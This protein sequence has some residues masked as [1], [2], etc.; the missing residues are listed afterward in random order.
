[1][2]SYSL[3]SQPKFVSTYPP[4]SLEPGY[5]KRNGNPNNHSGIHIIDN[6][7]SFFSMLGEA[8]ENRLKQIIMKEILKGSV[9]EYRDASYPLIPKH[10]AHFKIILEKIHDQI[11]AML[12]HHS[13]V[14][15]IFF[16]LR[17]HEYTADS[18]WVS[19]LFEKL[20]KQLSLK[21][22]M[23]RIGH[24]WTREQ[25][26]ADKQHYHCALIL[27][28]NK[29]RRAKEVIERIERICENWDLP[30]PYIPKNCYYQIKRG[31][32]DGFVECFRR[33]SYNAKVN[34]KGKQGLPCND[35]STSRIKPP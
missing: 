26:Q 12:S 35:Y 5:I 23:K 3:K 29:L 21:Y 24:V 17:C 33:L 9:F 31:A 15:V 6:S 2:P 25:E 19:R 8:N 14:I 1:M 30:K 34:G 10:A 7:L 22:K 27:D 18:K 32:D 16:N 28:G 11:T 13:R 4:S 20:K